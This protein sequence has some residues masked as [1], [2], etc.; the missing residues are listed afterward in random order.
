[1][2]K[3]TIYA[4]LL[5]TFLASCGGDPFRPESNVETSSMVDQEIIDGEAANDRATNLQ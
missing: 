2:T 3:V 4:T 1:M 5:A